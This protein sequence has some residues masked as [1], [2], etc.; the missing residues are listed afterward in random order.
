MTIGAALSIAVGGLQLNQTETGIVAQNIAR[1]GQAGYTAKRVGT[2][3][4]QGLQGVF[5]LRAVV[6]REFDKAVYSQVLQASAPTS[7][8]ETQQKYLSQID[9]F[10]GQTASGA[11]IPS[12]LAD[13]DQAMQALVTSPDDVSS[14]TLLIGKAQV[15]ANQLNQA[16]NDIQGLRTSVEAEI[17]DQIDKVNGLTRTISDLNARIVGQEAAGQD[18]SNLLDARDQAVKD[19]SSYMDIGTLESANGHLTVFT[20]TGLSLVSDHGTQFEFDAHG[21]LTANTEWSADDTQRSVG[22]IR[23]ADNGS[24]TVDLIAN[25]T[26]RSGSIAAL[27][28]LRDTTLVQAQAQLDDIAA[29]LSE[30]MSNHDVAGTATTSGA[31]SGFDVDLT[32][33]QS[34]NRVTLSYTDTATGKAK[35]VTLI[36]VDDPS[37]LPLADTVTGNPNDTVHG[38]D[39]SGGM[40]SVVSQIQTALGASFAVSNPSGNTLRILDD[41]AANTVDV[42]GLS[43]NVTSTALQD[44]ETGLPLFTDGAATDYYTGKFENGSQKTGFSTRISVN[45][46]LV[47]DPSLLLKWQTSPATDAGDPTRPQALLDRLEKVTF[48]F[49]A[50]TG[51]AAQGYG[52]STTLSNFSD[53]MVSHW[54]AASSSATS[55]LDSQSIIQTNLETRL[56]DASGVKVDQELARLIQ[57]QSSYAANARVMSTAKEMLDALMQI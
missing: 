22:T 20:T 24:S 6:S 33:L 5:G 38:I 44:G 29:G 4:Y 36:R 25:G 52:F 46:A 2:V 39:F 23:V 45:S 53:R 47:A 3:D 17:A 32:D 40:A 43:A 12:A 27:V 21:T 15:L 55:A 7:Y 26:L 50:E 19:L 51:M 56:N 16:S 11:S 28:E 49:G 42:T 41:G 54:G 13:F 9:Q 35:T 37:V 30:A 34:G 57:L 1:A 10:M 14:R 31:A 8:L 18:V 48:D